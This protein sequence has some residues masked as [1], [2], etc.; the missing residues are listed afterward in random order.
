MAVRRFT[1]A[2]P[3]IVVLRAAL[4][5]PELA[6]AFLGAMAR[7]ADIDLVVEGHRA[8]LLPQVARRLAAG[9]RG[10]KAVLAL[11]P[12]FPKVILVLLQC[13][14]FGRTCTVRKVA[15]AREMVV[16]I[17]RTRAAG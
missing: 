17:R 1:A 14:R 12:L 6:R 5:A 16:E 7:D 9:G 10:A 3:E 8:R 2:V 13:R 11:T 15:G 4:P